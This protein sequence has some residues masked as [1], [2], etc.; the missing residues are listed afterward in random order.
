MN[1]DE[2]MPRIIYQV[3]HKHRRNY[4]QSTDFFLSS[5]ESSHPVPQ[6]CNRGQSNASIF[7][8]THK[9]FDL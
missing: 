9:N 5:N 8:K 1:H 2:Q 7:A 6:E 4:R 3:A